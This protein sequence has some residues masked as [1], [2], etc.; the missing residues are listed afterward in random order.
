MSLEDKIL[1]EIQDLPES[2]KGRGS[3]LRGVPEGEGGGQGLVRVF[4]IV[5]HAGYGG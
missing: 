2:K 5:G 4:S 1:K 3:R